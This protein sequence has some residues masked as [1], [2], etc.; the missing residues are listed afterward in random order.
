MLKGLWN[1]TRKIIYLNIFF[2]IQTKFPN[3]KKHICIRLFYTA[4]C[5]V[6]TDITLYIL[7]K[8]NF[9]MRNYMKL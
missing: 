4:L 2:E 7:Y 1:I 9:K 3:S 8:T 5:Y 6:F